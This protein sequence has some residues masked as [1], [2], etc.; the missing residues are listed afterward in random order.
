MFW[1][2]CSGCGKRRL[3]PRWTDKALFC[4]PD[5]HATYLIRQSPVP[6]TAQVASYAPLGDVADA[7][8][9]VWCSIHGGNNCN[10]P[11]CPGNTP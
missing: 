2:R 7:P 4:N 3:W 5:C 8:R 10:A 11:Y 9:T 1:L 6:D